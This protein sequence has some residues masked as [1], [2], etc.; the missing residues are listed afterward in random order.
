MRPA[1]GILQLV[2]ERVRQSIEVK[3][4]ILA[5]DHLIELVNQTACA[6]IRALEAGGKLIFFGNGG[7]AADSQNLAAE[8]IGRYLRK[9]QAYQP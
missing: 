3:Q 2:T 4:A 6:C 1:A 5:D 8:L 9:R 7:S